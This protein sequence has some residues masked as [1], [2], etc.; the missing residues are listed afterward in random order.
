VAV[1]GRAR[2]DLG[3]E[4]PVPAVHHRQRQVGRR[5][6]GIE[7]GK[8]AWF[9]AG[10]VALQPQGNKCLGLTRFLPVCRAPVG[11]LAKLPLLIQRAGPDTGKLL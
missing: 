11:G 1:G 9:A 7:L 6:P 5:G 3:A 8:P 10:H 2:P 4:A